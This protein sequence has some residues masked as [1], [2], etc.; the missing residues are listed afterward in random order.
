M[1][2]L[3]QVKD[4]HNKI[5]TGADFP[6]YIQDLKKLWVITYDTFTLDGH[7]TYY[8]ESDYSINSESKY[9]P[10]IVALVAHSEEFLDNL[11]LHQQWWSDY[12]MFCR[13]AAQTWV[14][15]WTVDIFKMICTYY[16]IVWNEILLEA[17]PEV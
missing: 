3:Q 17:I 5:Q 8:G 16:D 13:H 14:H 10:L 7:T 15:H 1:F 12:M 4:A 6:A 11:R 2:T 9:S